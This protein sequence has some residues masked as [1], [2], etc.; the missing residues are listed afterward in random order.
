MVEFD[1]AK[2]TSELGLVFTDDTERERW[3]RH[4]D[5]C[6]E[7]LDRVVGIS[8]LFTIC[9]L[10]LQGHD[11]GFAYEAREEPRSPEEAIGFDFVYWL[12]HYFDTGH[13]VMPLETPPGWEHL[14]NRPTI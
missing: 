14:M 3:R 5:G 9:L 1:E 8:R 11:L 12:M 10:A 6:Q 4:A 13:H 7:R 2:I